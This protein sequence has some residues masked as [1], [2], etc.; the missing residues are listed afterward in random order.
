MGLKRLLVWRQST[1]GEILLLP[2][3]ILWAVVFRS[4]IEDAL[5]LA[6]VR[7]SERYREG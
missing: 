2:T 6:E 5:L 4:M 7:A 1:L 3:L